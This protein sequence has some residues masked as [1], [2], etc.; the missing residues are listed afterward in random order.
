MFGVFL[1]LFF[2]VFL[3]MIVRFFQE[4]EDKNPILAVLLLG[5]FLRLV[6]R[7]FN[8]NWVI[9]SDGQTLGGG[10]AVTYETRA[11]WVI[12][13]WHRLGMHF[14][15][16]KEMPG[17]YDVS[18]PPNLF[19]FVGHFNH[20]Y[21][22]IGNVSVTAFI[23]SLTAL[24]LYY[25]YV[26]H[27][28]KRKISFYVMCALFLSP[29]FVT[30]TSDS[31]KEGILIFFTMSIF[32]IY[33]HMNR[34][35]FYVLLPCL[36]LCFIGL[37]G[38]RYYLVYA[39]LPSSL[40]WVFWAHKEKILNL[41]TAFKIMTVLLIFSVMAIGVY[42][43]LDEILHAV[44]VGYARDSLESNM[45]GG[46]G[47]NLGGTQLTF[48][49]FPIKIL[50]TLFAPFPWQAGSLGLQLSKFEMLFWYFMTYWTC[51]GAWIF[52]K[53]DPL[54]VLIPFVFIVGMTLVYAGTF[55]N[56]GLMFRQRLVV[57]FVASIL[58]V[59]GMV[60]AKQKA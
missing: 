42:L 13:L 22:A 8:R 5:Y 16:N 49:V 54:M 55:E 50:Y 43:R 24:V 39:L 35:N 11:D 10:D 37:E 57:F 9:F 20:G 33:F 28:P 6:V 23:A 48:W 40:I 4:P 60:A 31:F 26:L 47:V 44:S 58:A 38:T 3:G 14:V 25:T 32:S 34:R 29:S 12:Q 2:A 46:S 27:D 45:S 59:W 36:I 51:R 17:F 15:T 53:R 19:A 1:A 41:N 56:I 7:T 30:Y 21:S 18:L 52:S